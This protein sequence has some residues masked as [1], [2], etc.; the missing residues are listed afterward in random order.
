MDKKIFILLLLFVFL[1]GFEGCASR[2]EIVKLKQQADYLEQSNYKMGKTIAQLDSL[3]REQLKQTRSLKA[4]M[5]SS[6]EEISQ[7]MDILENKL[8]EPKRSFYKVSSEKEGVILPDTGKKEIKSDTT[9]LAVNLNPE[10]LY[11]SAYLD[12]TKGNYDLA[13]VGFSDYLKYFPEA[14]LTPNAQYWIGECYFVKGDFT[15]AVV[16]FLKVLEKYPTSDKIPSTLYKLGLS[17][18]ELKENKTAKEY[19]DKLIKEYPQSQEAKLAKE[20]QKKP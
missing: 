16:E 3:I 5:N 4:D 9:K 10:K 13:I 19:L 6:F 12:L 18:S 20:R 2:Q 7:R 17:Y 14:D 11:K 15:R 8:E 1:F